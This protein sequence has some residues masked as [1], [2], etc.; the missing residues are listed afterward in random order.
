MINLNKSELE[1]HRAY[2]PLAAGGSPYPLPLFA[3]LS[4]LSGLFSTFF[5]PTPHCFFPSLEC[6]FPLR[7]CERAVQCPGVGLLQ[8]L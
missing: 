8:S 4:V 5:S 3:L 1:A 2:A 7:H 6:I